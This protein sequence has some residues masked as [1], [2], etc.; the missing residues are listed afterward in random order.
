ML[1]ECLLIGPHQLIPS[2]HCKRSNR[3]RGKRGCSTNAALVSKRQLATVKRLQSSNTTTQ[4]NES[5]H[6]LTRCVFL[7]FGG[8]MSR[9]RL[10]ACSGGSLKNGGS[11]STISITMMPSDQ[12]STYKIACISHQLFLC[13][14]HS[15]CTNV[16]TLSKW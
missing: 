6:V 7:S 14:N 1:N 3:G 10:I 16:N 9:M 2:T 5:S 15:F 12:M 4:I 13:S 11:P 8:G